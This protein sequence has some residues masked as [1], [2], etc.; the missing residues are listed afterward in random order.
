[1]NSLLLFSLT[2]RLALKEDVK[3]KTLFFISV[4]ITVAK[5]MTFLYRGSLGY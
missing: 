4:Y 3:Q 1:M 2:G 5:V